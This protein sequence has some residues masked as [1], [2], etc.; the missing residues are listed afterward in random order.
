MS[1]NPAKIL[2]LNKGTLKPGADADITILDPEKAWT[3]DVKKFR[4]K[5][6]N[7]PLAAGN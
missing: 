1:L 2:R 4:S 3:V 7:S 5:S 6:R